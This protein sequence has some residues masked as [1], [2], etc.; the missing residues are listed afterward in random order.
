MRPD[1][2][3]ALLNAAFKIDGLKA[4]IARLT[5]TVARLEGRMCLICG[6][7]APCAETPD[8]CTFDPDPIDAAR[9][10]LDRATKAEA[11][12][13]RLTAENAALREGLMPFAHAATCADYWIED[14][15]GDWHIPLEGS[16]S[17][18]PDPPRCVLTTTHLRRAARLTEPKETADGAR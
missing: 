15:V 9:G 2:A 7:S 11:E 10:F 16:R 18:D 12:I 1:P 14:V 8:A 6:A 13:A 3:E 5:S 17:V 4:E